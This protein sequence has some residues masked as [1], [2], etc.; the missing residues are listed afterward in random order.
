MFSRDNRHYRATPRT[1]QEAFGPYHRYDI[2][3]CRKHE[4]LIATVGALFVGIIFGL[5]FGWRG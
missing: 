2:E 5:L 1:I 4:R 3:I